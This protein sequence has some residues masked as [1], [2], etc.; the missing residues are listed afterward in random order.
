MKRKNFLASLLGGPL[1][2]SASFQT[3]TPGKYQIKEQ[4]P[5]IIPPYLRAGD[6]IGI[7][8]PAGYMTGA[9]IEP[10]VRILKSWGFTLRIGKTVGE[11]DFTFGGSDAERLADFQ[12]MLDDPSV[13]AIMCARGGY[14]FVRIIDQLDFRKFIAKPKWIV[15]FSDITVLHA[16]LNHQF[17]IASIHSKMCN[18]FPP[19]PAE[20]EKGQWDSILSIQKALSGQL[21][22]YPVVYDAGNRPGNGNGVL[23]GGN[24]R[25]IESLGGSLSDLRTEGT[26]LFLE[27]AGEYLY[28]IDRM[29][30]N[31]KRSGKLEK[32][33]GLLI[34]GF[35]VKPDDPGDEFGKSVYNIVREQVEGYKYPV[36]FNFPVGHQKI[37]YALKCGVKYNLTVTDSKVVFQEDRK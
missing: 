32:L 34:G 11:R 1:M 29:F 7:T 15:G 27:D 19:D 35:K 36:C 28:S 12:S 25:T 3:G 37:N 10:A 6:T 13:Q 2:A 18:S 24:L 22:E 31:L 16:H 14:G 17:R 30:Y 5:W 8:C 9:D 26:I 33:N 21:I 23:T 4:I 20:T